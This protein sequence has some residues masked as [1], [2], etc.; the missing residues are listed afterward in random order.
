LF[1][2]GCLTLL[3]VAPP[4]TAEAQGP[5]RRGIRAGVG[6]TPERPAQ[7]RPGFNLSDADRARD[8]QWRFH[9]HNG[10][11]WYWS[12]NNV[13]MYHREGNWNRF[14]EDT[15][16]PNPTFQGQ[17]AAGFRG[18][19][20]TFD[21]AQMVFVDSGGRA[22]ICQGGRVTFMDGTALRTVNR[23]QINAQGFFIDQTNVQGQ[24]APGRTV[25]GQ[26]AFNATNQAQ[27]QQGA[28]V[29]RSQ[30]QIDADA[31][32]RL[33]AQSQATIQRQPLDAQGQAN[34]QGQLNAQG[35]SNLQG[36]QSATTQPQNAQGAQGQPTSDASSSQTPS[37]QTPPAD[38]NVPEAPS[39]AE[40][41]PDGESAGAASSTPSESSSSTSSAP[42]E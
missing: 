34:A 3:S 32:A 33:D 24:L 4:P 22:V 19:T 13:W 39:A 16:T 14:A 11:W 17:Y 6:L 8:A 1:I 42:G 37:T 20:T 7:A 41:S 12:P 29:Q 2:A 27:F 21:P 38:Q 31:Q 10:D 5:V 36:E 9:R 25:P 23:S 28:T 15:F 30:A 18:E 40:A 26:A 35:Q